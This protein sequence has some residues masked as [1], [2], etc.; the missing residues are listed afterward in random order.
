M[1]SKGGSI[2]IKNTNAR[3]KGQGRRWG[4]YHESSGSRLGSEGRSRRGRQHDE[5]HAA[6]GSRAIAGVISR[7]QL[8]ATVLARRTSPHACSQIKRISTG[9]SMFRKR[10]Y[11]Q[12]TAS[13]REEKEGDYVSVTVAMRNRRYRETQINNKLT[14]PDSSTQ[15]V[16]RGSAGFGTKYQP[17]YQRL[18]P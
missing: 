11:A 12:D 9:G 3:L 4:G 6:G 7:R 15:R 1:R 2:A 14:C 5:A 10:E 16:P 18:G 8:C 17:W 13:T